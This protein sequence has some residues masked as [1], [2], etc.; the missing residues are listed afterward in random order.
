MLMRRGA[1]RAMSAGKDTFSTLVAAVKGAGLAEV[2][3]GDGPFT[4]FAPTNE[5]FAKLPAGT[6]EDLLRPASRDRLIALL[7]LHVVAGRLY[8]DQAIAAGDARTLAGQTVHVRKTDFGAM[9]GAAKLI[10]TDIDACNGV[11]HVIDSV[12]LPE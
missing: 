12:L 9:V 11:I 3:S 7:K 10:A 6:V 2:L 4:I 5:A 1:G 8:S